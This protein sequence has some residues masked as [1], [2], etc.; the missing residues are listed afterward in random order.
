MNIV[1]IDIHKLKIAISNPIRVKLGVIDAAQNIVVKITTQSGLYGWGEASPFAPITGDSQDSNYA[2]A[3]QMARMI[4]DKDALAI[5][6][7]MAEINGLSVG[8]PSVRSAFDMAL[9]DIAAKAAGMP[10]YRFLGGER[11]EIRTD[12]T[13]GWRDTVA[14]TVAQAR[15]ILAANFNAIKLKV[16]RPG[17]VDVAHVT[18]VREL[19]GP[20]IALKIDSN[21]GWD[22]PTAVANI[23][24]MADLDL[25][26][27]EQPLAVWDYDNMA[28]LRDK[29]DLPICADESVFD[30]HDA[31]KLVRHG[32][33]D[34]LNIKLGKAGGIHTGLKINAIAE[35]AGAK[36][37]IGCFAESRLGLSAAAHL[38]M[39]RPNITFIDLDSCYHF[40]SDPVI[41]GVTFD[42]EIGGLLH[43]PDTPGHGAEIDV[44]ALDPENSIQI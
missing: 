12:L 27:A 10:L 2:A 14:D 17:L 26:Y 8:E 29:V 23:K 37:M 20:D 38:A 21:Q 42:D 40:K 7:R 18:A 25:D 3:Q 30:H 11:R 15:N 13:I 31:L 6:A 24:A 5:E 9:Y 22:Y 19:V 4:K 36:C 16:G 32:A 39:A 35:A 44:S 43:L 33:A 41:G 28:R 1:R 34:Y